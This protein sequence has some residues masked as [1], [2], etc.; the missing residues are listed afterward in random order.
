V[1]KRKLVTDR[2]P[3]WLGPYGPTN[4]GK[5]IMMSKETLLHF[6]CEECKNWWS[7]AV[8][9]NWVPK[10][11]TCTHCAKK[12]IIIEYDPAGMKA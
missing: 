4:L 12:G 11:L 3:G 9:D 5:G 1:N 10:E 6:T 8:M 2:R 7:I